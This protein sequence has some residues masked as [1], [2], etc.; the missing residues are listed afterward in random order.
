MQKLK[1]SL[2]CLLLLFSF[3]SYPQSYELKE[4]N[5]DIESVIL[6]S[7]SLTQ[8]MARINFSFEQKGEKKRSNDGAF[9]TVQ[10]KNESLIT[11][12][13]TYSSQGDVTQIIFLMPKNN[14]D[15]IGKELIKRYGTEYVNGEE[16]I[17]RGYLTYDIRSDGDIGI[18]VI[19]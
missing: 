4:K 13:V 16:V 14:S 11:P 9:V 6:N 7:T 18:F 8:I 5:F 15:S 3:L 10:Y 1:L 2:S 12:L 17:K 19:K